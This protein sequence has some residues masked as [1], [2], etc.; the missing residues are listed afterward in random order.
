VLR[1]PDDVPSEEGGD[2]SDGLP[3]FDGAPLLDQ[4]GDELPCLRG[5]DGHEGAELLDVAVGGSGTAERERGRGSK[6]G[7]KA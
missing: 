6:E 2:F 4:K 3:V 7:G 5:L 1:V